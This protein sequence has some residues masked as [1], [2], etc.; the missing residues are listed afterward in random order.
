ML[1]LIVL[2]GLTLGKAGLILQFLFLLKMRN[3]VFISCAEPIHVFDNAAHSGSSRFLENSTYSTFNAISLCLA[4][5]RTEHQN[6]VFSCA[7]SP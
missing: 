4:L 5:T 1:F 2:S 3:T 6:D 7:F